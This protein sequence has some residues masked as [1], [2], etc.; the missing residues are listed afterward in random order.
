M[1]A[2]RSQ[3]NSW[4]NSDDLNDQAVLLERRQK[5]I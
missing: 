4:F 1:D 3:L 2:K 5:I